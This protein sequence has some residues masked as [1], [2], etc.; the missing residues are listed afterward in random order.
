MREGATVMR[1]GVSYAERC[2][3][4][5]GRC[6]RYAGRCNRYAENTPARVYALCH[7]L[8]L[9]YEGVER[10]RPFPQCVLEPQNLL[11]PGRQL[12]DC[13]REPFA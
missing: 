8:L 13:L 2:N 6:N 5:A 12:V 10:L 1:G 4:Y 7:F 9:F 3:R 11:L